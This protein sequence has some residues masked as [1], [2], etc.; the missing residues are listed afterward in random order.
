M[1]HGITFSPSCFPVK[2]NVCT[3]LLPFATREKWYLV[4]PTGERL[5]L[6]RTVCKPGPL[7]AFFHKVTTQRCKELH[8]QFEVQVWTRQHVFGRTD[9]V[10]VSTTFFAV[11]ARRRLLRWRNVTSSAVRWK[12]SAAWIERKASR[13]VANITATMRTPAHALLRTAECAGVNSGQQL[14]K[15]G[16]F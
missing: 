10:L 2:C 9:C 4:T 8:A 14:T 11:L 3:K 12:T 6:W 7:C 5:P 1:K 16:A 13:T 15:R